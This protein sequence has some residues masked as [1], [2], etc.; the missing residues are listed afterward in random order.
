[1]EGQRETGVRAAHLARCRAASR[2]KLSRG[3]RAIAS[4]ILSTNGNAHEVVDPC[5]LHKI[6]IASIQGLHR[7]QGFMKEVNGGSEQFCLYA[8]DLLDPQVQCGAQQCHTSI[9]AVMLLEDVL[10][11]TQEVPPHDQV[12][13]DWRRTHVLHQLKQDV[14]SMAVPTCAR[15]FPKQ[16]DTGQKQLPPAA[17][18][19]KMR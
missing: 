4:G 15:E 14:G 16:P 5:Q 6:A 3:K 19:G 2:G 12:L 10:Q 9:Q 13:G 11:A 7:S 17:I 1:M 8:A 18:T